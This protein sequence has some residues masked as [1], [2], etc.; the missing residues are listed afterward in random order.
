MAR[1]S[2]LK[3]KDKLRVNPRFYEKVEK[4]EP[5]DDGSRLI[6]L[7]K[8][9]LS[10]VPEYRHTAYEVEY[11]RQVDPLHPDEFELHLSNNEIFVLMDDLRLPTDNYRN[12]PPMFMTSEE[13]K[14]YMSA[15]YGV[16]T[17][18]LTSLKALWN[19]LYCPRCD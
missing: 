1:I 5:D 18:C 2:R 19:S 4:E 12:W 13:Y 6:H 11:I 14:N 8:S 10:Y 15:Y 9:F 16:C 17:K 3:S 7:A